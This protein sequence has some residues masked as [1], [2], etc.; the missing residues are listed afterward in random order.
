MSIFNYQTLT[1]FKQARFGSNV[2]TFEDLVKE[3]LFDK[4]EIYD[5]IKKAW[6]GL[7]KEYHMWIARK[8]KKDY[9]ILNDDVKDLP[10]KIQA[11]ELVRE[12]KV[13]YHFVKEHSKIGFTPK[14]YFSFRELVDKFCEIRHSNKPHQRLMWI[15]ALMSHLQRVNA[16][17]VGNTE[18]GKDSTF[19]ILGYL[20][21]K[22]VVLDEP[23]SIPRIKSAMTNSSILVLNEIAFNAELFQIFNKIYRA[24]G[25]N[26]PYYFP[27]KLDKS[28]SSASIDVSQLSLITCYNTLAEGSKTEKEKYFEFIFGT[29]VSERFIPFKFNGKI[30]V[31][32]FNSNIQYNDDVDMQLLE[33]SRTIEWYRQNWQTEKKDWQIQV[34]MLGERWE[35]MFGRIMDGIMLYAN[36]EDEARK[37]GN[38]LLECHNAY[39]RMLNNN[40]LIKDY[41]PPE[42][43]KVDKPIDEHII[44]EILDFSE[45][46]P[47]KQDNHFYDEDI[48]IIVST[49]NLNPIEWIKANGKDGMIDIES[50]VKHYGEDILQKL[51][52]E[53]EVF[54]P[55]PHLIKVL[56]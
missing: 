49:N 35:L 16:R 9:Q 28:G 22:V 56:E 6:S 48:K 54:S 45:L 13:I 37:E 26:K 43:V 10:I 12:D 3:R 24:L 11:I 50:F 29:P 19:D 17:V 39:N 1:Q 21:N 38:T 30:D 5:E 53:A 27:P 42:E 47:V 15:V 33:I 7:P 52:R 40:S 46:K 25:S 55:R 36:T 4:L 51:I 18:L 14:R 44:P 8:E 31:K 34:P 23:E 2:L 41:K 32:Q 20:T